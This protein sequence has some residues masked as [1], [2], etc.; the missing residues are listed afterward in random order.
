MIHT[1]GDTKNK[2]VHV[3][4]KPIH[5]PLYSESNTVFSIHIYILHIYV[6]IEYTYIGLN[7][8]IHS[9]RSNVII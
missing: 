2:T 8:L 3:V 4:V 7:Y 6:C 5:G 9:I 1:M